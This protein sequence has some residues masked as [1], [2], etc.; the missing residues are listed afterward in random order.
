[1]IV[2]QRDSSGYERRSN[3]ESNVLSLRTWTHVVVT[4]EHEKGTVVIYADGQRVGSTS[5]SSDIRYYGPTTKPYR[6]GNDGQGVDHQFQGSVMDLYV[7][8]TALSAKD[9]NKLRG[10]RLTISR[11]QY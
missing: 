1:M 7:F 3:I 9:I 10:N 6:I 11:Y 4:W 8:G 2:F 5:F